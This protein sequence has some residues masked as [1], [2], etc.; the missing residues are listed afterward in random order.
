MFLVS[1]SLAGCGG[2]A[3]QTP[4]GNQSVTGSGSS[5]TGSSGTSGTGV[6]G[7]GGSSTGGGQ[8]PSSETFVDAQNFSFG[9][10]VSADAG[11]TPQDVYVGSYTTPGINTDNKLRITFRA[12]AP[13]RYPLP[14]TTYSAYY[15]CVQMKVKVGS[16]IEIMKASYGSPSVGPCAGVPSSVT[17]DF[18]GQA[19]LGR[20]TP[21]YIVASEPFYDNCH[22]VGVIQYGAFNW[23]TVQQGG[24]GAA[25]YSQ[26]SYYYPAHLNYNATATALHAPL[27]N[28][29]VNAT[30]IVQTSSASN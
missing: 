4:N 19:S 17:K 18:S 5:G 25:G 13:S 16:Q 21:L 11:A 28:H 8:T 20:G 14:G 26:Q 10:Q 3:Y 29:I 1:S 23:L 9:L 15:S 6:S 2:Q 22:G 7:N 24:C 30:L 27:N 12:D